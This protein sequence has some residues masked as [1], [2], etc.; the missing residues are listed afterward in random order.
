MFDLPEAAHIDRF[1]PKIKFYERMQISSAI[2]D[3]FTGIIGRV[4]WLY[5]LAPDTLNIPKSD[6]VEEFHVLL[7]ELK[8]KEI[9]L[10][11]L[12]VIDKAIPYPILHVLRHEGDTCYVIQHKLDSRR[13]YYKTDWNQ[14]P[15]LS[16]TGGDLEQVYQRIITG[17][18]AMDSV[19][20]DSSDASFEEIVA[21]NIQRDQLQKEIAALENKVRNE[22]QFSKKVELNTEL[23]RKKREL[24]ELG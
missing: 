13:R 6:K 9:P 19:I 12:G 7:A 11:A 4:T 2:R 15:G 16:F 1:I 21:A 14:L 3:E 8:T 5:R 18:I 22:K 20:D 24:G 17:F 23:Q 10:K